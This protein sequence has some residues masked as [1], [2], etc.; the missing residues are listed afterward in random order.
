MNFSSLRIVLTGTPQG[1]KTRKD[2]ESFLRQQGAF[3]ENK[4]SHSTDYLIYGRSNTV[5]YRE[6]IDKGV[7][8]ITYDEYFDLVGSGKTPERSEREAAKER[9]ALNLAMSKGEKNLKSLK[10][11][12]SSVKTTAAEW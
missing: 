6:A 11:E 12:L 5:K 2:I 8:S 1:Q 7:K 4:I 9:L 3:I 10:Q